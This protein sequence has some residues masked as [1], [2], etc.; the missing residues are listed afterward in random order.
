[1]AAT[2]LKNILHSYFSKLLTTDEHILE[3]HTKQLFVPQ[4][5]LENI[6]EGLLPK[7]NMKQQVIIL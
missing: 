2:L 3:L 4:L 1:M 7:S 5:V 6:T